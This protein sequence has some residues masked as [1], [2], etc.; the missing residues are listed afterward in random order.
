MLYFNKSI[1]GMIAATLLALVAFQPVQAQT[2]GVRNIV[3]VHG[4]FADGSS[5]S[6]V[7]P[8]LE[9][10]GYKVTAVQNPLISLNG[11][12]TAAKRIVALQDGPVL[13]VGHSWGGVVITEA[14]NDPKV[15]GLVY[16]AAFAPD[17]GQSLN[18]VAKTA[19]LAPGND[20]VRADSFG[21]LTL[22]PK[23]IFENFALDL[24]MSERKL[25][26]AT[27]GQWAASTTDEK[28]SKAAWHDKPSWYIVAGRDGMINPGLQRTLAKKIKAQSL[29]LNASHVPMLSQPAKV[30]AFIAQAAVSVPD[31]KI[32]SKE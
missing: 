1:L 18:D 28:V 15:A 14:G 20:Q 29:E 21:Y 11:D 16:V 7:I 32:A 19:P 5:W 26:L 10:K 22:T 17:N 9:A 30:A 6:K 4:A 23:G 13:L 24:P 2:K 27:Q 25:I 3:L 8:L 12:V 31:Q